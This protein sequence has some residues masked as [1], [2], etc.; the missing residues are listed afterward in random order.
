MSPKAGRAKIAKFILATANRPPGLAASRFGGYAV[1]LVGL[2]Y[3]TTPPAIA[4]AAAKFDDKDLRREVT[5]FVGDPGPGW[6]YQRID[7]DGYEVVAIIVEPP[8]QAAMRPCQREGDGSR[9]GVI[10]L[11]PGAETRPATGPQVTDCDGR[12]RAPCATRCRHRH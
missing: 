3:K 2:N 11:R 10:Y 7:V 8:E 6:D 5:S 12:P 1:M 9:D 4:G